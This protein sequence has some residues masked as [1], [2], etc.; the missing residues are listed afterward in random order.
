[1]A[2]P[3]ITPALAAKVLLAYIEHA[4]VGSPLASPDEERAVEFLKS[5]LLHQQPLRC[6]HREHLAALVA[7]LKEHGWDQMPA[8]FPGI[9]WYYELARV[10]V[11]TELM[12]FCIEYLPYAQHAKWWLADSHCIEGVI[13]ECDECWA[14]RGAIGRIVADAIEDMLAAKAVH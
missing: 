2:K 13:D 12:F 3:D 6:V 1:M 4:S 5:L 14:L 7:I 9:T 11:Q 8:D 10:E